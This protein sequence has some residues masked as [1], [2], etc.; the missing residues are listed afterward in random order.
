MIMMDS[1]ITKIISD[2]SEQAIGVEIC[3][4]LTSLVAKIVVIST[5]VANLLWYQAC[6]RTLGAVD[7]S[8]T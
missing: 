1:V 2:E 6:T 3:Y 8:C 4:R 5:A 7:K